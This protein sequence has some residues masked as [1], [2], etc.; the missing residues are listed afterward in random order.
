MNDS[1]YMFGVIEKLIF[2]E[3]SY[4]T[5]DLPNIRF[6][7]MFNN[8]INLK[9]V[10][11]IFLGKLHYRSSNGLNFMFNNC[12][13]LRTLNIV[14]DRNLSFAGSSKYM[15]NNC[16]SLKSIN[17]SNVH[18]NCFYESLDYNNIFSNCISLETIILNHFFCK[19]PTNMS[20]IFYNCSSL[21][22][23]DFSSKD[24]FIPQDMN[25]SFAYCSSLKELE[26]NFQNTAF[27]NYETAF[28]II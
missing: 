21:T 9:N 7:E 17:L 24:V 28:Y 23:L 2:A 6:F 14:S 13:N 15:F 11:F 4:L 22:S 1:G 3:F 10:S 20:Y 25:H 26:L 12:I 19:N 16:I 5:V 8:C 18:F 27:E